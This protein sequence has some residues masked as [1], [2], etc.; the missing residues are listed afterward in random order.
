M[1][2]FI[3][4][5][6]YCATRIYKICNDTFSMSRNTKEIIAITLAVFTTQRTQFYI[7]KDSVVLHSGQPVQ[8]QK[9]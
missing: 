4:S 2:N 3:V 8:P 6:Q 7:S 1:T 5:S 9:L